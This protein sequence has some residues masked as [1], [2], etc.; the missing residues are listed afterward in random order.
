MVLEPVFVTVEPART[1]KPSAETRIPAWLFAVKATS[2]K[3]E[4][5]TKRARTNFIRR[6]AVFCKFAFIIEQ[7][8]LS[9]FG[10]GSVKEF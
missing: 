3:T 5:R 2:G 7:D 6:T 9:G 10:F 1:A 8:N 4:A